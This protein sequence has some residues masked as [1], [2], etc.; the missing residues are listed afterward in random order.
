MSRGHLPRSRIYRFR[1]RF[2]S[3]RRGH[4]QISLLFRAVQSGGS[5]DLR[6]TER[7]C[8]LSQA[9]ST[10]APVDMAG[11]HRKIE[12]WSAQGLSQWAPREGPGNQA[13][14]EKM[15]S[16]QDHPTQSFRACLGILRLREN[17]GKDRLETACR[18]ILHFQ[19]IRYRSIES[20]F[21][22]KLDEAWNRKRRPTCRPTTTMSV[23]PSTITDN[24]RNPILR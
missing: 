24:R 1:V 7:M 5:G 22:N 12:E 20:I 3:H 11:S 2:E 17:Y 4:N 10:A 9:G 6:A 14:I 16:V 13:V 21:K 23:A 18:R 19:T 8:C 15:M